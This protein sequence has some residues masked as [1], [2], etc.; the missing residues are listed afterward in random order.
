[1]TEPSQAV[2]YSLRVFALFIFLACTCLSLWHC[3][4]R[5][6]EELYLVTKVIDGDTVELSSGEKL[7]YIGI[8][9]PEKKEP[10]YSEAK[11]YNRRLL[12]GKKIKIE[13]DVQEKDK[14]GRLLGYVYVDGIFVNAEMLK[15]GLAVLY[16][17]PPNV[18]YADYFTQIQ[19]KARQQKV[20]VWSEEKELEEFYLAVK[21]SKRF[22]RPDCRSLAGSKEKDLIRL[23]SREEALDKGFSACRRC[24]P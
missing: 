10:F 21:G 6:T 23:D 2:R 18:K 5:V 24:K 8:D 7:R 19:K 1:M 13:F 12:E 16:T 9:T 20:G 3:T 17:Y 15:A 22:H 14:Y 4:P 11:N